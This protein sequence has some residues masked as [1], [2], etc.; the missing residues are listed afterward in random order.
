MG[1]LWRTL[2]FDDHTWR[3]G[4]A[5]IATAKPRSA[6]G[7]GH[8]A[9]QGR[10][11]LF[12]RTVDVPAALLARRKGSFCGCR[13]PATTSHGVSQRQADR[14]R[15]RGGPRIQLLEPRDRADREAIRAGRNVLAFLVLN[16]AKQLRLYLDAELVA[17]TPLPAKT[18]ANA[19]KK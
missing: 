14:R 5:P 13:L 17:E 12:R 2:D 18:A 1:T 4:K 8:V 3:S 19:P 10:S 15:S 16:T 9:E 7:K 11:F 6:T